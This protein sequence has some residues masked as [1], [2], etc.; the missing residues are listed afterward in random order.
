MQALDVREEGVGRPL[1]EAVVIDGVVVVVRARSRPILPV[2]RAREA[3][4]AV[5]DRGARLQLLEEAAE[6][7]VPAARPTGDEIDLDQR[8]PGEGRDAD[9][10]PSAAACRAGKYEAYTLFIRS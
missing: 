1:E 6:N 3:L 7:P 10:R 8:A 2:D 5:L 4:Q 9:A